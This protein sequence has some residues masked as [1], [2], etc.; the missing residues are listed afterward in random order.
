[1]SRQVLECGD[2]VGVVTAFAWTASNGRESNAG[3]PEPPQGGDSGDCVAALQDLAAVQSGAQG[4]CPARCPGPVRI[5]ASTVLASA[6]CGWTSGVGMTRSIP[7]LV[8]P[9]RPRCE[10]ILSDFAGRRHFTGRE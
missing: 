3:T 4:P 1:M 2:G 8:Y 10:T 6:D 7:R 5:Q 9:E